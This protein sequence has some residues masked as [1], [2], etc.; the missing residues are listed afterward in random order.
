MVVLRESSFLTTTPY[1]WPRG[2]ESIVDYNNGACI[3][4]D[5]RRPDRI[6]VSSI[7]GLSGPD[8][9][10][11][12]EKNPDRDGEQPLDTTYGGRTITLR[13][14]IEAGNLDKLRSLYS[15]LLDGFDDVST[16]KALWLRWMDWRDSFTDSLALVDY[17]YDAGSATLAIA[18]DGTGL[19]PT[20]TANKALRISPT[21][22]DGTA[23]TRF[24]YGDGEAIMKFRAGTSLTG[25]V[26]GLEFRRSSSLVK[27]RAIYEKA[28]DTLR[29]YK[30]NTSATQLSTVSTGT[31]AIGTDYWIRARAEGVVVTISIWTTY[32]PDTGT[33]GQIATVSYTLTGGDITLYPSSTTGLDWGLYWTPNSTTDRIGLL[34]VGALN[35]GDGVIFCRKNV[36]IEGEETQTDFNWRKDF[37]ITLRASDARMVSRK[38]TKTTLTPPGT[39]VNQLY[40]ST[41]LSN[42]GRSPADWIVRFN[43]VYFNP[44]IFFPGSSKVL[45]LKANVGLSDGTHEVDPIYGG[46]FELNTNNR[47]VI[48][49]SLFPIAYEA[50]SNESTWPQLLRGSNELRITSDKFEDFWDGTPASVLN[51]RVSSPS[52]LGTWAT[53][54][55]TTDFTISNTIGW[56]DSMQSAS[57]A[58]VSDTGS[59]RFAVLGTTNYTDMEVRLMFRFTVLP[60]T[61][62]TQRIAILARYTNTSNYMIVSFFRDATG[63]YLKAYKIV[64]GVTTGLTAG[65]QPMSPAPTVNTWYE[66]SLTLRS[67]GRYSMGWLDPTTDTFYNSLADSYG[68]ID[69]AT[70]WIASDSTLATAGALA[71]GNI[72]ILDFNPTVTANTRYYGRIKVTSAINSG[73]ID[74][75]H[76]HSS[77]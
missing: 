72:G 73:T 34:D 2:V 18:S 51:T 76:R 32:P 26:A 56:V 42:L 11:N 13:G 63:Y 10:A 46:W 15:Y 6:V 1:S 5:L 69:T 68:D 55:S 54:G 77:R 41:T 39:P 44:R 3:L 65:S 61:A 33:T 35:P 38:V 59:G 43:G 70:T 74:I 66:L 64:A 60:T 9:Q 48:R 37:M 53:S 28:T 45:G 52:S 71:T 25:L 40:Y 49:D 57:R 19:Q 14:Y 24:T 27:L 12:A 4:N 62:G 17:A 22:A 67:N 29:L 36:Q 75:T 21:K 47:T 50:L 31:L 58:T 23:L 30:I 7:G 20:T 8:L 16:E